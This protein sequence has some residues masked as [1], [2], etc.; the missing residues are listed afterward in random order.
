[1]TITKKI[2]KYHER[3][4][5]LIINIAFILLILT[6]FGVSETAPEYL[7]YLDYYVRIYICL[8]LIWRFNPLRDKILFTDLDAKISFNAGLFILTS[9]ALNE[10]LTLFETTTVAKIKQL[11]FF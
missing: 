7:S 3:F 8:F 11:F 1:M 2:H 6:L 9:T 10:Y 4:F 5:D